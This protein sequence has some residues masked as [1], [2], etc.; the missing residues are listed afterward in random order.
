MLVARRSDFGYF[1][2]LIGVTVVVTAPMWVGNDG[3]A[4]YQRLDAFLRHGTLEGGKYS[5]YG[6]LAASPLW[7]VGDL[8]GNPLPTVWLLNR[9]VFLAGLAGLWATL[10]T[11]LPTKV[12][13]RFTV[14]LLLA[15]MF[16]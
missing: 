9:I 10:S 1:L 11:R 7:L 5:L 14:L 3:L 8:A 15:S 13:I 12:V 6:P 16:P 4:R 2:I